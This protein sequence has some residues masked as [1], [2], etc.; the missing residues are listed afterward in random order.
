M[1]KEWRASKDLCGG[2]ELLDQG[3]HVIDL[4]RWFGGEIT[5]LSG[6]V[7][8]KFWQMEVEDN[9]YVIGRTEKGVTAFFQVSWTNWKNIFLFE[10][11]GTDGY[12][13]INGLGGSYG[14]ESLEFGM[15][16]R[17]GGRPDVEVTE[18][19]PEDISWKEEWKEFKCAISENRAPIGDGLD[20][21]K[22]N[23]VIEAI[24]RSSKEKRAVSL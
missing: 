10:V 8:T 20:G 4:I 1:E 19:P 21:L 22:A 14:T 7:E 13:K 12:L 15:R 11:Y 6:N 23:Q 9:A 2:G 24:Y 5:E 3:V 18:F 16:K 17:E